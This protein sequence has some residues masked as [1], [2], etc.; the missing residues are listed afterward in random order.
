MQWW[1]TLA[2]NKGNDPRWKI[3]LERFATQPVPDREAAVLAEACA[4][5]DQ[6]ELLSDLLRVTPRETESPAERVR[7]FLSIVDESAATLAEWIAALE[8]VFSSLRRS[9]RDT[10]FGMALGYL[11]CC[12]DASSGGTFSSLPEAAREMIESHGYQG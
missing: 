10:S 6:L 5:V 1:Q 12:S 4:T 9:G 11:Q 2:S 3:S 8:V 7:L